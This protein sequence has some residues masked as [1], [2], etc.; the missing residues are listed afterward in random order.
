M[1]EQEELEQE[2]SKMPSMA[3]DKNI[4]DN[5]FDFYQINNP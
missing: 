1:K 5:R 3:G 2:N 4:N